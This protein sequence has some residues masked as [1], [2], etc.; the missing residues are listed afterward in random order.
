V[1]TSYVTC[2]YLDHRLDRCTAQVLDVDAEMLLC[3][4]HLAA[5]GRMAM[6][7]LAAPPRP[8]VAPSEP[9]QAGRCPSVRPL[10]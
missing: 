3:A 6:E 2:H 9:G 8:C 5:A 10:V 7:A 1:T 4:K